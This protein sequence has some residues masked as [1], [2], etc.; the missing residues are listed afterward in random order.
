MVS[1]PSLTFGIKRAAQVSNRK[2]YCDDLIAHMPAYG[3]TTS[4]DTPL[5]SADCAQRDS[6]QFC[7][8]PLEQ[9]ATD[10]SRAFGGVIGKA[11]KSLPSSAQ[12][13]RF[14]LRCNRYWHSKV[15][16]LAGALPK[17]SHK[18]QLRARSRSRQL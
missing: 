18:R 8:K 4:Q 3:H 17:N 6:V 16:A 13:S 11:L 15:D 5:L 12:S 7:A 10:Q 9:R 1:V 2:G 14:W